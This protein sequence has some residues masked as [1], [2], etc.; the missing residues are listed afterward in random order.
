MSF[1]VMKAN[2][3]CLVR[4]GYSGF[5]FPKTLVST[6]KYQIPTM[7]HGGGNDMVWGCDYRLRMGPLRRILRIM[8]KFQYED[9][10]RAPFIRKNTI[11]LVVGSFSNRIM[12]RSTSRTG[13]LAV[14]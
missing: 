8:D 4:I 11:L 6:P 1:G 5:V 14:M 13:S 12:I 9:T 10:F 3:C 2:T 7:K